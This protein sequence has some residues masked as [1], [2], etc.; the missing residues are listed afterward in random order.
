MVFLAYLVMEVCL[1]GSLI[2]NL[3]DQDDDEQTQM[4]LNI[5]YHL[6]KFSAHFGFIFLML[7]TAEIFP[8]S[9]RWIFDFIFWSPKFFIAIISPHRCTGF[10][11]CYSIKMV[12]ALI[13]SPNLVKTCYLLNLKQLKMT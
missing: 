10:G 4:T 1:L 2:A 11:L 5:L 8:T 9:L 12:G 7:S 3:N 6:C 13:S